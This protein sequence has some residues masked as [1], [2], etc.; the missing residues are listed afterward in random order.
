MQEGKNLS[1]LKLR[2]TRGSA[3]GSE[4][5]VDR[6]G[7]LLGRAEECNLRADPAIDVKVSSR[8]ARIDLGPAGWTFTDLGSTNG[9]LVDN[10]PTVPNMPLLLQHGMTIELGEDQ[11]DGTVAF[12]VIIA[13]S[14]QDSDVVLSCPDCRCDFSVSV[15]LLGRQVACPSCGKPMEVPIS[16]RLFGR[17]SPTPP[18]PL[19]PAGARFGVPQHPGHRG[20]APRHPGYCAEGTSNTP[21]MQAPPPHPL[22]QEPVARPPGIF[23][24]VQKAVVNFR[25]R[26]EVQE[27]IQKCEHQLS[28]LRIQTDR[29]LVALGLLAW[30]SVAHGIDGL[31]GCDQLTAGWPEVASLKQKI[32]DAQNERSRAAATIDS[33]AKRW[34]S[35]L[36]AA[37]RTRTTLEQSHTAAAADQSRAVA[38][39]RAAIDELTRG[40]QPASERLAAIRATIPHSP[41]LVRSV[42]ELGTY[43]REQ[44]DALIVGSPQLTEPLASAGRAE[45][46][47]RDAGVRAAAA[48]RTCTDLES[49]MKIELSSMESGLRAI[50]A[51]MRRLRDSLDRAMSA[52]EPSLKQLGQSLISSGAN[53][54]VPP[55]APE[56]QRCE[57]SHARCRE[58]EMRIDSLQARLREL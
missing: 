14:Q 47:A 5:T 21:S 26:R 2:W 29:D 27:E 52:L 55:D 28:P 20:D 38:V 18:T 44:G 46:Q 7:A 23:G 15:S 50:D 31:P 34:Q 39:L 40:V 12:S 45:A 37:K 54:F 32:D 48:A 11:K 51:E 19:D 30:N 35:E 24:R 17:G 13:G 8:H 49:G 57:S 9:S 3:Q 56:W 22:R 36:D 43:L 16:T 10:R 53:S 33:H 4:F 1:T 42:S 25:E 6:T 41:D 58:L